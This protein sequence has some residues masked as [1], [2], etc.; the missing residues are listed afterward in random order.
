M[1]FRPLRCLCRR[2]PRGGVSHRTDLSL[3]R[4]IRALLPF[5]SCV[6]LIFSPFC[7]LSR[8]CHLWPPPRGRNAARPLRVTR[9]DVAGGG[10]RR[11]SPT[12]AS[13]KRV[14]L[15]CAGGCLGWRQGLSSPLPLPPLPLAWVAWAASRVGDRSSVRLVPLPCRCCHCRRCRPDRHP[16]RLTGI[17]AFG[18]RLG[19]WRGGLAWRRG[20]GVRERRLR[21]WL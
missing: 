20:G 6:P 21:E 17:G 19:A 4:I 7:P 18:G 16:R 5:E 12:P 13:P 11:V 3:A 14:P 8:L 1:R 2:T 10:T 15:P 9:V